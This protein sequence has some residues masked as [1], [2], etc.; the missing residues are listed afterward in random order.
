MNSVY[1]VGIGPGGGQQ[2][3]GEARK[4]L[5]S[6]DVIIGYELA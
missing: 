2:M 6:C 5:E 4:A 3:T 1:V